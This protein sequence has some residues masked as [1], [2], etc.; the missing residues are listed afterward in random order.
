MKYI[1]VLWIFVYALSAQAND[2]ISYPK[3]PGDREFI[4]DGANLLSTEQEQKIRENLDKLLTD[5]AIPI[6]IVTI[7]SLQKYNA[8]YYG[9][10]GIRHYAKKL[11]DYWGIG[12][13]KVRAEGQNGGSSEVSWNKGILLLISVTDRLARIELGAD[14]GFSKD[15]Q[16]RQIMDEHIIFYF[17]QQKFAE[18]IEAG[19]MALEKMARDEKIPNP[20]R[21]ASHYILMILF[22]GLAIFTFVSLARQG[23]SGWAWIFWGVVF[24]ILGSILIGIL[25][26][27]GR[28]S[29]GSGFSGGSFGG[30][31]SGGGGASGSW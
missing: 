24:S 3:R 17:R 10:Y 30:G 21:P 22:A 12:Y 26:S 19:A 31:F 6:I 2:S 13:K 29:G 20:P 4:F 11:F 9:E 14:Y 23:A 7:E 25:T 8:P 18:G 16:S 5:K 15:A 27:S 1:V 28:N